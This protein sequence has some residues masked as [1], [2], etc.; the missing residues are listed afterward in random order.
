MSG[1]DYIAYEKNQSDR[2]CG[3]LGPPGPLSLHHWTD[4]QSLFVAICAE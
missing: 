1:P 4:S 3:V 2:L